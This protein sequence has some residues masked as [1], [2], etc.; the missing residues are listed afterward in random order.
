[1][2]YLSGTRGVRKGQPQR[3]L[4]APHDPER[5][6]LQRDALTALE[7][8]M[9]ERRRRRPEQMIEVPITIGYLRDWLVKSGC[10]YRS[11]HYARA[12]LAELQR[13]GLLTDTQTI[14]TPRRQRS[15]L[16]SRWWR[17]YRVEPF[18]LIQSSN[19]AYSDPRALSKTLGSLCSF[20]KKQVPGTTV[21]TADS[22]AKGSVQRA[23][24]CCGPP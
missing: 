16:Q 10:R 11:R 1:M 5:T 22:F 14:I 23:F 18:A 7:C 15:L 12:A 9:H 24:A 19:H 20:L 21:K 13:M 6:P 4:L 3:V 8:A 2:D 17:V